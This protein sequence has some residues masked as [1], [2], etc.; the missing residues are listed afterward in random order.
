VED[1]Q[2]YTRHTVL[3]RR[4]QTGLNVILD[5]LY[6]P[7]CVNCGEVVQDMYR[8]C[9][10]C[11]RETRFIFEPVCDGCGVGL[12]GEKSDDAL[13]CDACLARPPPWKAG[14][15]ALEYSG[16]GRNLVLSLK[17]G[18]KQLIAHAA[19][20][21]VLHAARNVIS[22]NAVVVPVPLHPLR[23]LKR[24][25]NQSALLAQAIAKQARLP[26]EPLALKRVKNTPQLKGMN[27]DQRFE[28]LKDAIKSDVKR[29]QYLEGR[30]VM[31]VDD[32][33]TSG[34][35][36]GACTETLLENGA[37]QVFVLALARAAVND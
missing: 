16:V 4:F 27:F 35:T 11:W 8:L 30:T 17:H 15:C 24:R 31:L 1:D 20:P 7:F 34:A 25:Y 19:A 14:R 29:I 12:V 13:F 3:R 26:V 6:P 37:Q 33:L 9:A 28:C 36:L 18:G 5:A 22:E 10:S 2:T 21:W 23:A 32:V